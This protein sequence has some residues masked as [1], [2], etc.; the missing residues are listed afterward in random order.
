MLLPLKALGLARNSA[1][2]IWSRETPWRWVRPAIFESESPERTWYSST[3]PVAAPALRAAGPASSRGFAWLA[4]A[5]AAARRSRSSARAASRA[6]R[7][8]TAG[9][10]GA[11]VG[12]AAE[13]TG[14][15]VVP[16]VGG[17]AARIEAGGS[18]SSVYSRT[19]RPV[20][21]EISRITSTN[22]SWTP[23]SL[24]R[25]TNRRPSGRFSNET[26]VL[27]RTAL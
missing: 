13:I 23:R 19:S 10:C 6:S 22:G 18:N 26:R 5:F 7:C 3:S 12:G 1:T 15:V 27:G 4:A 20:A 14:D 11:A 24:T 8:D 2:S 21:Q 17:A 16:G 9:D 25:R